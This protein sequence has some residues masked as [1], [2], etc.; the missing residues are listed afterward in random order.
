[1]LLSQTLNSVV[2]C[3]SRKDLIGNLR[4]AKTFEINLVL[5][6]N[7]YFRCAKNNGS[8]KSNRKLLTVQL[9]FYNFDDSYWR[10]AEAWIVLLAGVVE[11]N[12]LA[13][14]ALRQ[15]IQWSWI[16]HPIFQLRGGHFTTAVLPP[17]WP[18]LLLL[19]IFR[20]RYLLLL[21]QTFQ[22]W[23][24]TSTAF[25]TS[26]LWRYYTRNSLLIREVPDQRG[27]IDEDCNYLIYWV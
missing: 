16:E 1:V 22:L 17:H 26:P 7:D 18:L 27:G 10:Q 5:I 9:F 6:M 24:S 11:V 4:L 13:Q 14:G 15:F 8:L 2:H 23:I 21:L 19:Q 25:N 3:P 20:S 12:A